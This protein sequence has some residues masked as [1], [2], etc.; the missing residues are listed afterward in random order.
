MENSFST[1]GQISHRLELYT[2]TMVIQGSVHG[3]F[4]RVTDL[5]NR[6]DQDFLAVH[7]ATITPLG[8]PPSQKVLDSPVMLARPAIHLAV[9]LD[10][11]DAGFAAPPASAA[12][13]MG[14]E[15]YIRKRPFPCYAI[16][17]TYV[18]YGHCHLLQDAHLE[19]MLRGADMFLPL[20]Q[21]TMYLVARPSV[22]WQRPVA[23]VSRSALT[24]MYIAPLVE[25]AA[26]ASR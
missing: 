7:K 24:A 2:D 6:G 17:S 11:T 18:V 16:T 8:Q 25:A 4:K 15:S 13:P 26:G 23:I 12:P 22:T 21:A 1:M 19:N 10:A 9:D 5:L 14:R 3:P 20:T